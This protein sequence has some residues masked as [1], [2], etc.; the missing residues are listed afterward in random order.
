MIDGSDDL[1]SREMTGQVDFDSHISPLVLVGADVVNVLTPGESAGRPYT[2]PTGADRHDQVM[3]VLRRG[4]ARR[5]SLTETEVE[6]L[7]T[8]A[9]RL[10]PVFVAIASHDHDLAAETLNAL[11]ARWGAQPRLDR[12]DNEPWHLHFHPEHVDYVH[13]WA[14][15][16]ATGLAFV[17]GSE[18]AD[19]LGVCSAPACDRVYADT[20]RNGTKRFCSTACQNRVKAAAFR[21]RRATTVG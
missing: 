6:D 16:L 9:G 5:E 21:A 11:M 17:V 13:G 2:P 10:R 3:A 8:V 20:S 14:A 4:G 19:R 12:H 15:G 1:K 18:L 7:T